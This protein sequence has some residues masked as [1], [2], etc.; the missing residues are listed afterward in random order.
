ML[1]PSESNP[2]N[3]ETERFISALKTDIAS[4]LPTVKEGMNILLEGETTHYKRPEDVLSGH[5]CGRVVR[6]LGYFLR[7][8]GYKAYGF[9]TKTEEFDDRHYPTSNHAILLITNPV[10]MERIIVDAAYLQFLQGFFLDRDQL[11]QEEV[12][13]ISPGSDLL[14][15]AEEFA[16]LRDKRINSHP[17]PAI[18][19]AHSEIFRIPKTELVRYFQ[20][21]WDLDLYKPIA[22][23]L[24]Q[25]I[26]AYQKD[27]R[28][29]YPLTRRLIEQ[30]QLA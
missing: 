8:K 16:D 25:D 6:V 26:D 17:N 7:Q 24:E 9:Q 28:R 2:I 14:K 11:P 13:I 12:L 5:V 23:T 21:I 1:Q 29:V 10:T 3:L 30:L 27:P 20:R 19:L 15:K 4:V 22:L 18:L